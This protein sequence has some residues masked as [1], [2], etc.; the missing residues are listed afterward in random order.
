MTSVKPLKLA[1]KIL[2]KVRRHDAGHVFAPKDFIGFGTPNA[3]HKALSRLASDGKLRR[4]GRGMYDRP[5][6]SALVVGPV[7]ASV[8][9]VLDAVRRRTNAVIVSDNAAAANALGL[10][11][12]LPVRPTFVANKDIAD[13]RLGSRTIRFKMAGRV[14]SP[15]LERPAQPIVQSLIW[16][17]EEGFSLDDAAA[18]IRQRASQKAKRDLDRHMGLLPNWMLPVA[19]EIVGKTVR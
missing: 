17:R 4:V 5:A 6:T 7:P 12:A 18:T 2:K 3:V 15:W 1:D 11:T 14:L 19:Q 9:A 16:L 10:T 13:I 8:E